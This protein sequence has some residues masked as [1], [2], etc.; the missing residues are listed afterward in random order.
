MTRKI[1]KWFVQNVLVGAIPLLTELLI[2]WAANQ[3]V[4]TSDKNIP[5]LMFL[6]A[7]VNLG[8]AD[9]VEKASEILDESNDAEKEL[10][11][12]FNIWHNL[13]IAG[14]G[15]ACALFGVYIAVDTLGTNNKVFLPRFLFASWIL[16]A[17][18][19]LFSLGAQIFINTRRKAKGT[20]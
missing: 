8:S 14:M 16:T 15:I 13:L 6:A 19:F 12:T 3:G 17:L 10:K 7:M 11:E 20:K 18:L 9:D 5:E 1:L 2:R 4:F